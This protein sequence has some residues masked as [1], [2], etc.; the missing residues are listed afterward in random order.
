MEFVITLNDIIPLIISMEFVIT[1]NDIIPLIIS[2]MWVTF[3]LVF[4]A[5]HLERL[6]RYKSD[7]FAISRRFFFLFSIIGV[8]CYLFLKRI[9]SNR[10]DEYFLRLI[11]IGKAD[12]NIQR[13]FKLKKLQGNQKIKKIRKCLIYFHI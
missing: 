5:S 6:T 9:R 13:Y 11:K 8:F 10:K 12:K 1:L 7:Y 4:I 3:N 2:I